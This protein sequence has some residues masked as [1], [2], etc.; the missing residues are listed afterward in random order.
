M[1][2]KKFLIMLPMVF[3]LAATIVSCTSRPQPVEQ[4]VA[5]HAAVP[6]VPA[7]ATTMIEVTGEAD[8]KLRI[9]LNRGNG[10]CKRIWVN[11]IEKRCDEIGFDLAETYFCTPPDASSHPANTNINNEALYCGKIIFMTE[12]TDIQYKAGSAPKNQK[13]KYVGGAWYCYP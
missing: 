11:D 3:A 1:K 10:K 2:M 9:E 12:E 13:C 8:E 7:I 4:P 5:A 6:S